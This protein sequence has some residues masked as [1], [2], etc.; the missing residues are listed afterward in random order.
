MTALQ[1]IIKEAK[2]LR[3]K[4]PKRFAKWTEYVAQAS[5]IYASKHKGKSPVGKKKVGAVKKKSAPKKKVAKKVAKKKVVKKVA[6]K[7]YSLNK[8]KDKLYSAKKPGKRLSKTGKT[9]YESRENRSDKGKLLGI[10]AFSEQT[11]KKI[12]N[13]LKDLQSLEGKVRTYTIFKNSANYKNPSSQKIINS[14]IKK[15]KEQI[16]ETKTHINQ[17]KKHI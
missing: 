12:E 1:S 3:S 14:Y 15:A 10:G 2:S 7:K 6:K 4:Y 16:K 17:L 11:L 9:Y 5:A 13:Q 8:K